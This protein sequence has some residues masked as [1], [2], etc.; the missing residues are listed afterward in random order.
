MLPE[1]YSSGVVDSMNSIYSFRPTQ[2][3]EGSV[4]PRIEDQSGTKFTMPS[5]SYENFNKLSLS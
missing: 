5:S 4:E 3:G 1:L 2:K